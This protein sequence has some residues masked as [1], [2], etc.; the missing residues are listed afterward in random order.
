VNWLVISPIARNRLLCA[1]QKLLAADGPD[2][3]RKVSYIRLCCTVL[4][5]GSYPRLLRNLFLCDQEWWKQCHVSREG[6]LFSVNL[7][8]EALLQPISRLQAQVSG[9]PVPSLPPM[10]PAAKNLVCRTAG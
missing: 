7:R 3:W 8:L 2:Q 1:S 4:G 10:A 9:L 6:V 5:P